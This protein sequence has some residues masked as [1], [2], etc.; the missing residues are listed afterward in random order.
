[1]QVI[2]HN[3]TCLSFWRK[4]IWQTYILLLRPLFLEYFFYKV[5]DHNWNPR[6]G[7]KIDFIL[8]IIIFLQT[9]RAE[10]N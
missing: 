2:H 4:K 3:Q 6:P 7:N 8:F 9:H 1:M 10:A 5:A